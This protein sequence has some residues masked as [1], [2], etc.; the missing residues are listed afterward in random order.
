MAKCRWGTAR[1]VDWKSQRLGEKTSLVGRGVLWGKR[2]EVLLWWSLRRREISNSE[3]TSREMQ[4]AHGGLL[5]G[6][7]LD[8]E[9][10]G[11]SEWEREWM[12]RGVMR[13]PMSG[14]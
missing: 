1:L 4:E 13:H 6:C 7:G 9:I 11:I 8:S 10:S 5:D 2:G 3:G 12:Y 14:G